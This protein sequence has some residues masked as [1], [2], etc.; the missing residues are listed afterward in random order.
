MDRQ[1]KRCTGELIFLCKDRQIDIQVASWTDRQK[2]RQTYRWTDRQT[3]RCK[4]Y[5]LTDG[6]M[7]RQ[8][9]P[10]R[11]TKTSS[12][13]DRH[14]DSWRERDEQKGWVNRQI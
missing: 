1:T 4:M 11:Y 10:D 5:G 14:M 13:T 2:D 9:N 7:N 12:Y 3:D 6:Q 8:I